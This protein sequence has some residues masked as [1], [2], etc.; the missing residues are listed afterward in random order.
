MHSRNRS[1]V[2]LHWILVQRGIRQRDV[3]R[4][5]GVSVSDQVDGGG[6]RGPVLEVEGAAAALLGTPPRCRGRCA[7]PRPGFP[8]PGT[9]ST[10]LS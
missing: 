7:G 5:L 3:A 9:G 4:F 10:R 8:G 6:Q 2:P 1:P